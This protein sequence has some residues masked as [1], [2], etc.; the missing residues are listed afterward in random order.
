MDKEK[1]KRDFTREKSIERHK[2]VE[3]S[4]NRH[5]QNHRSITETIQIEH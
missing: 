3:K 4:P 2:P 1:D 5:K